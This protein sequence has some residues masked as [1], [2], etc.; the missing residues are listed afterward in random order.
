MKKTAILLT[1]FFTLMGSSIYPALAQR[2]LAGIPRIVSYNKSMY[3]GGTQSWMFTQSANGFMYVANNDGLLEFDGKEWSIYKDLHVLNRATL[4]SNGR[5][6]VGGFYDFGY[7]SPNSRGVLTY[8]SITPKLRRKFCFSDIWK[9]HELNNE[10]YF[11]SNEAIFKYTG[12]RITIIKAP[13]RFDFSFIANGKLFV[14]DAAKGILLLEKGK[15]TPIDPNRKVIT[16]QLSGISMLDSRRYLISTIDKG[17]FVYD[18]H[19]ISEWDTPISKILKT[20]QI[21][22]ECRVNGYHAIGTILNGLYIIDSEGKIVLHINK[23]RGLSN[24]TVLSIGKDAENNIWLGLNNGIAKVEFN[25]SLSYIGNS[26]NIESVY[27]SSLLDGTLFVGTNSGLYR[28]S[29]SKF[30]D[31]MKSESDFKLVPGS[32]GQVWNLTQVGGTLFCGHNNGVYVVSNSRVEEVKGVRGAWL[33]IPINK[34]K[35]KVLVGH[36]AGIAVIEKVGAQWKFVNNISGFNESSRFVEVDDNGYIWVS[37]GYKGIYKLKPNKE[38]TKFTAIEFY[39]TRNGLPSDKDNNIWRLN[40]KIIASTQKGIYEY[41]PSLNRFTANSYYNKLIPEPSMISYMKQD[42]RGN[43]WYY[44]NNQL[45]V[46]RLQE[47]EK[48]TKISSPFYPLTN[49]NNIT[50]EHIASLPN[51]T[52]LIGTEDGIALYD[53]ITSKGSSTHFKVMIKNISVKGETFSYCF[54]PNLSVRIRHSN[55]PITIK[56]SVPYKNNDAVQYSFKLEGFDDEWSQWSDNNHKEYMNLSEGE[57]K[58]KVRAKSIN[59][60]IR[61]AETKSLIILPPWHRTIYAY[62]IYFI[63]LLA[64]AVR[65]KKRYYLNIEKSRMHGEEKQKLRFKDREEQLIKDALQ[66]ENEMI[67]IKNENL[68]EVMKRK[69]RELALSTMHIIQKNEMINKMKSELSKLQSNTTDKTVK[70][71]ASNIIKKISKD[72]D[73]KS[74]WKIFEM[75]LEQIHEDFMKRLKMKYPDI[76]SRELRLCVYLKMNMSSKEIATLMNISPRGVEISRYRV[77]KKL[78]LERAEGLSEILME[79]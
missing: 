66:S 21:N 63:L 33:F 15:L 19:S 3:K 79:I 58:I 16:R 29:W 8:K 6:Y 40:G 39:G 1:L 38:L 14:N 4:Y 75:H 7:Y 44:K 49:H 48:Y 51:N 31:P 46:L 53:P 67:R 25:S 55:T 76:T 61:E 68:Q 74:D 41:N 10:I 32:E 36:Y 34:E 70:E 77:R 5:I 17:L 12:S 43:I 27:T 72:I 18:G 64:V 24:N 20:Y 56:A 11:Q 47:D 69:E 28:I 13:S 26:F 37:H 45:S 23:N 59:G 54:T 73:N 30:L 50:F 62:I 2:S 71:K 22:S 9:I 52:T 42:E 60:E 78:G 57:Y 35:T 65:I